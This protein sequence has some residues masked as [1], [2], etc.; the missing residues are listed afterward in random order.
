MLRFLPLLLSFILSSLSAFAATDNKIVIGQS[1][2]LS[3]QA[4]GREN[5]L[6]AQLYFNRINAQ[7]GIYGRQIELISYDDQR[8][9]LKTKENTLKLINE[10]HAL[11]LFGYRST[12]TVEAILPL[13]EQNKIPLIAPFS[14]AQSLYKPLHPYVFNL[15][16]SY[17]EEAAKMVESLATLQIKKVAILHQDD[18]FG[19]DGLAGFEKNLAA[20][21]LKPVVIAAYSR[22]DL[23]VAAA[24]ADIAAANPQA[25]LMACTPTA[26]ADFIKKMRA[27]G[28]APQF[29]MLS[30]VNSEEFFS[31]L[32]KDG[33]GIGVMQV[34]PSP[35]N[36]GVTV[37]HEFQRALKAA[38]HPPPATDAVEE[39]FIA[40]KLL[41]E[42]LRRAGANPSAEKL[43]TALEAMRDVDLGGLR[44]N[45]SAV[46]HDGSHF[47]EL[48]IVGQNGRLIR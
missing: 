9:P 43:V 45:Y 39:G 35:N 10:N 5:M 44:V 21:Q 48:S 33:R 30:N 24:V 22:K 16:A 15:R 6:G 3:G 31:S 7:G 11:A 27:S 34:T 14:G 42:G 8:D 26:C 2:E 37:V 17:Q 13:L 46:N 18:T 4:T 25:V 29:M 32:G 28:H 20:R 41:T 36:V 1:V 12:P 38:N 19:K 47:V 40:A 23:N